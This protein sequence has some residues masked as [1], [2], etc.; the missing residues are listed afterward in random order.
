MPTLTTF[1]VTIKQIAD[2]TAA[3]SA[4]ATDY[5]V[6]QQGATGTAY[7]KM[8]IAQLFQAALVGISS[9][10]SYDNDADAAIGGVEIGQI[11]RNG[12]FL[13]IRLS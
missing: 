13:M 12:N 4:A 6:V 1:P 5:V 2:L 10:P 3:S 11:Y 8:T 7:R 9:G